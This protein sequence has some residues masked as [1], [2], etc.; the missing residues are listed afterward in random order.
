LYSLGIYHGD[1]SRGN[2]LILPT[3]EV[4]LIDFDT[5]IITDYNVYEGNA[6]DRDV[7]QSKM[8]EEL[9]GFFE[10]FFQH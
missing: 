2:M 5:T 10:K 8:E 1:L 4:N 6:A 7:L 9:A 3:G